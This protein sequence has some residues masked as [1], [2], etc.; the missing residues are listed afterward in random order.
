M[1]ELQQNLSRYTQAYS[2]HNP[3]HQLLHVTNFCFTAPCFAA[4]GCAGGV[5]GVGIAGHQR[6]PRVEILALVH[7]PI[8]AGLRQPREFGYVLRRESHAVRHGFFAVRVIFAAAG[9]AIKQATM[10][11][12]GVD[13]PCVLVFQLH[14]AAL[15]TAIAE[16]F[17]LLKRHGFEWGGFPE[18]IVGQGQF[19]VF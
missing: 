10:D 16:R 8:R 7:Q 2:T 4:H 15:P 11:I 5:N 19:K 13:L 17:P 3:S 18:R 12:R 14:K 9:L 6:M 1:R